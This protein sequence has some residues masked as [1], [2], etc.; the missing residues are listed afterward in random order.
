M[1]VLALLFAVLVQSPGAADQT[2][3][4]DPNEAG[5]DTVLAKA[6]GIEI[7]TPVRPADLRG[8]GYHPRGESLLDLE[9]RGKNISTNPLLGVFSGMSNPEDIRYHVMNREE[10]TGP[11]T[12]ALDVG[13]DAGAS[14]YAPVTGTVTAIRPDPTMQDAN[15]V[16]IKPSSAPNAR[17]FVSLVQ[18]VNG[19]V[20]PDTMVTAGMTEIGTVPDLASVLKP[21]LSSY[22]GDSGNH[23]T[24]YAI[25]NN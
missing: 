8:L 19:S 2:L 15:V 25:S 5:P 13:A 1:G 4:I 6:E 3:P 21:Q 11:G 23:V 14:V 22:T 12:G 16:E 10:R 9:P 17:V 24:V 18:D 7:S 20:G